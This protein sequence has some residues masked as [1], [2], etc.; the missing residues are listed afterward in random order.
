MVKLRCDD[1][2]REV[3]VSEDYDEEATCSKCG[4]Y[5]TDIDT[6]KKEYEEEDLIECDNCKREL[7]QDKLIFF[8]KDCEDDD[9]NTVLCTNCLENKFK[10]NTEV[11]IEYK[12]RI[13]EKPIYIYKDTT[14]PSGG[15]FD[16]IL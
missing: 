1:C 15:I 2:K 11:K 8:D 16:N 7:S 13:V 5:F 3:T 6:I 9:W 4:G 10:S 12:E 14:K